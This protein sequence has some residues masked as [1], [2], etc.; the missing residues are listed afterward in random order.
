MIRLIVAAVLLC[1][2]LS[3]SIAQNYPSRPVR[4]V[5]PFPPGGG[6]DLLARTLG[7]ELTNGLGQQVIVDNR[8]GAQGNVGTAL[9]AKALP[10][11]YTILLA[12]NGIFAMNPWIFKETGFDPV[13]DFSHVSLA[14]V[15]PQL[16]V[17]NPR[18]PARDLRELA[19]LARQKPDLLS[20]ASGA[21][22]G[23]L[24]GELFKMLSK[25]KILHVPYKG[26]GPAMIDVV[27]GNVDMMIA[28]P[29][30]SIPMVKAGKLR[31][32]A[33]AGPTRLTAMPEIPTAVDSGFPDFDA[34]GWYAI[35]G[36]AHMPREIVARLHAELARILG[37][38]SVKEKL[39]A[40]GIEAKTNSPEEMA[41]YVKAE[42]DRW[43]K[44]VKIAGVKAE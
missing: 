36:P 9:V 21:A 6:T 18:V 34:R 4:L 7:Q 16:V 30:T 15:Q 35:A 25:T 27:A 17:V 5:V 37:A 33:V 28:S 22:S 26:G 29:P 44:V 23:H 38:A 11:G 43:G 10:D 3:C 39:L 2:H 14:T 20:F 32:I 24:A 41:S 42:Y 8:S 1:G 19:V 12:Q 31:A 40:A 13:R